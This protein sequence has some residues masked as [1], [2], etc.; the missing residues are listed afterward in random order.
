MSE[1]APERERRPRPDRKDVPLT[2]DA[3]LRLLGR[4]GF[5]T[6][7][8][9]PFLLAVLYGVELAFSVVAAVVMWGI[10]TATFGH[11]PLFARAVEGDLAALVTCIKMEPAAFVGVLLVGA[12][13]L[14]AYGAMSWFLGAGLI[15]VVIDSPRRS[16]DVARR[17]VTA[18]AIHAPRFFILSLWS[19][20]PRTVAA[21]VMAGGLLAVSSRVELA[22]DL[23]SVAG[24]MALGLGPG[25]LLS[26]VVTTAMDIARVALVLDAELEPLAA[27]LQG[28]E[29]IAT[30]R[31][32]LLHTALYGLV[33]AGVTAGHVAISSAML[34]GGALVLVARQ[35]ASVAR[36]VARAAVVGGQVEVVRSMTGRL[37]RPAG[38]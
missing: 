24:L 28:F 19:L 25:L 30:H 37:D 21:V 34:S 31:I 17:F 2:R 7:R 10:L 38:E 27:L 4:G 3:T 32:L 26:W 36:F 6:L 35:A 1:P 8:R 16:G 29:R 12:V 9:F 20:L 23:P 18:A 14:L 15:A 11:R 13:T 22:L 5:R 33:F